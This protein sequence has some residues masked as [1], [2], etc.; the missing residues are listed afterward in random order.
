MSRWVSF[1]YIQETKHEILFTNEYILIFVIE[2]EDEDEDELPYNFIHENEYPIIKSCRDGDSGGEKMNPA[3]GVAN[4]WRDIPGLDTKE[5]ASRRKKNMVV[6]G[7][8]FK[9]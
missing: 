9:L 7:A 4:E 6:M 2:I 5:K 8:I 3:T 1:L